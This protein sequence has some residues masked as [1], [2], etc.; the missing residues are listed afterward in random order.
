[1]LSFFSKINDTY[2]AEGKF[3][4]LNF[5]FINIKV[6][7]CVNSSTL[8]CAGADEVNKAFKDNANKIYFNFYVLNNLVNLNDFDNTINIF[9]EDRMNMLIDRK[10]YKVE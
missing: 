7:K 9:L 2:F 3:S 6:S 4:S 1:M 10:F 5:S 8:L